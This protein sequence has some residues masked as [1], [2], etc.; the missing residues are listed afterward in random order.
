MRRLCL[1]KTHSNT[2]FLSILQ[3]YIISRLFGLKR[4]NNKT[5]LLKKLIFS[6]EIFSRKFS[7]TFLLSFS[8]LYMPILWLRKTIYL[9]R[10]WMQQ[11]PWKIMLHPHTPNQILLVVLAM[12]CKYCD[13]FHTTLMNLIEKHDNIYLYIRSNYCMLE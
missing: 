10:W 13:L 11:L 7:V 3:F 5:I 2:F 12:Q 8:F 9:S 4:I 1:N 6:Y